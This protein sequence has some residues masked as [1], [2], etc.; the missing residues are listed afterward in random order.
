VRQAADPDQVLLDFLQ[1]TYEAAATSAQWN[2]DALERDPPR[3]S[4]ARP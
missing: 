4:G 3:P 2:R 1:T